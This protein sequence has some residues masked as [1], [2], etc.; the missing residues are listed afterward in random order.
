MVT[1][2]IRHPGNSFGPCYLATALKKL[3]CHFQS[4]YWEKAEKYTLKAENYTCSNT[5]LQI[6]EDLEGEV[7]FLSQ[8]GPFSIPLRCTTKKCDVSLGLKSTKE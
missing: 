5:L 3:Y 1:Q 2:K 4:I 6:N 7:K 8:T